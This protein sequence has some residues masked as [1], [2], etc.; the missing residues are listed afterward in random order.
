M[1]YVFLHVE[2]NLAF[3]NF[4]WAHKNINSRD[5]RVTRYSRYDYYGG[6]SVSRAGARE[7]TRMAQLALSNHA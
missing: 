2:A 7:A 1:H 5:A 6:R 3:F 4:R